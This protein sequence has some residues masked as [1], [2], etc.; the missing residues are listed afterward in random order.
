MAVQ[1]GVD[2]HY[3]PMQQLFSQIIEVSI[4]ASMK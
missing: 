4:Q 1:S 2:R 3:E